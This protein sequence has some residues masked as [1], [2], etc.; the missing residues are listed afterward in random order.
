MSS[1][2]FWI[3]TLEYLPAAQARNGL[4][5]RPV[6]EWSRP[7]PQQEAPSGVFS[8]SLPASHLQGPAVQHVGVPF[9]C[10]WLIRRSS[11]SEGSTN[12]TR[13]GRVGQELRS[14]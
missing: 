5:W 10:S 3:W 1:G 12:N 4:K 9:Y 13:L 11:D 2:A 8:A 6:R 14:F 7:R